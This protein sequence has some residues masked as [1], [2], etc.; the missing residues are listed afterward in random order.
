MIEVYSKLF[1]FRL[2]KISENSSFLR[3]IFVGNPNVIYIANPNSPS[4]YLI[5]TKNLIEIVSFL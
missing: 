5:K 3:N 2:K 1:N 4:G